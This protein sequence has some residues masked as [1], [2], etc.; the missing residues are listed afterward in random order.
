MKQE[1]LSIAVPNPDSVKTSKPFIPY[2][3]NNRIE[4]KKLKM[5]KYFTKALVELRSWGFS[6]EEVNICTNITAAVEKIS[7][8]HNSMPAYR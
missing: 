8:R 6:E 3:Y 5:E 7:V 4:L 2:K 1:Q